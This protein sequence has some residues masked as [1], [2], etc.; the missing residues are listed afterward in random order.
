MVVFI[1]I[2]YEIENSLIKS[3]RFFLSIEDSFKEFRHKTK[4]LHDI[5]IS[6]KLITNSNNTY[7]IKDPRASANTNL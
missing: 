1:Y 7:L 5:L 2:F 6:N 3:E 4:E